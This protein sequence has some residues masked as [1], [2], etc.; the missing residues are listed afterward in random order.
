MAHQE[1]FIS[2]AWGGESENVAND[3]E[4]L[5][6]EKNI[7]IVRDKADLGFK[8][9]IREFMERIG[10][11]N[12]VVLIISD[13]Y[14]KSKNCMFELLEV[15]KKGEFHSRVFP[16][17]LPDA[18]IYDSL[19]LIDYYNYWDQ[20]F[21]ELNAKLSTM[22]N[23]SKTSKV[24]ETLD[25]YTDIRAAID[26]LA[27]K[28]SNMNTLTLEIMRKKNFQPLLDSLLETGSPSTNPAVSSKKEGKVLYHIPRM[29][30]VNSWSKCTVR[31]A[32]EEIILIKGLQ[33]PKDQIEIESIRLA[34][35]MQVNLSESKGGTNFEIICP[36]KEEQFITEDEFTEWIYDVKPLT[37]GNFTLILKI[38]LIRMIEGQQRQKDIVLKRE[39]TTETFVPNALPR[40]K[41]AAEILGISAKMPED[42]FDSKPKGEKNRPQSPESEKNP[43]SK[44]PTFT[45]TSKFPN[46]SPSTGSLPKSE[47]SVTLS[48]T[49]DERRY[50][51]RRLMPYVASLAGIALVA[52]LTLWSKA[53]SEYPEEMVVSLTLDATGPNG[54]K[55]SDRQ[56]F[57]IDY[58]QLGSLTGLDLGDYILKTYPP[59]DTMSV[60]P[61]EIGNFTPLQIK[62][63][64]DILNERPIRVG[65]R[66]IERENIK[67]NPEN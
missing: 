20:Q 63:S 58:E 52:Y 27:G 17:V 15:A 21:S 30:Q 31:L 56:V 1:V 35:V 46:F 66:L 26:D 9:L 62:D 12:L 34:E 25:L 61:T 60:S 10:Q 23:L 8:G 42:I 40:L 65:N 45:T 13:R 19:V 44:S 7:R 28:L 24:F 43:K 59:S 36:S 67:I 53:G 4:A 2:Y 49:S 57:V 16:L 41:L 29:M 47:D 64:L 5:L 39:V 51:F 22:G 14:L 37:L 32:W 54:E 48:T 3:L 11:G 33:I 55:I 6:R 38:S 18:N 50:T